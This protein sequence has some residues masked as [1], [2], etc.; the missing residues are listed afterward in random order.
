M[1]SEKPRASLR[2][3]RAHLHNLADFPR[4]RRLE[5]RRYSK[6]GNLRHKPWH[7]ASRLE[8]AWKAS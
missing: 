8:H 5:S 2:Q 1:N 6:F 4:S 7:L 3:G